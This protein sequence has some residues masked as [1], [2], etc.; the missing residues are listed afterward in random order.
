MIKYNFM[1]KLAQTSFLL[2]LL[3]TSG[4]LSAQDGWYFLS[5]LQLNGGNYAFDSYSRAIFIYGGLRYQSENF[6]ITASIPFVSTNSGRISQTNGMMFTAG[7]YNQTNTNSM[8]NKMNFGVGDLYVYMDHKIFSDY[9]S[10]ID[11]FINAQAKIPTAAIRMNIGTGKF[12]LGGSVTLRKSLNNFIGIADFGY[13]NIGDPDSIT[14][15][16]PFTY[17]IGVGKFFN[18]GEY[19]L[20]IYYT[21]YTKI[22]DGFDLPNLLSLGINYVA[23]EKVILSFISSKGF[24]NTSPDFTLSIGARIKI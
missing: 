7:N 20:L 9:E 21:G 17:G 4:K 3:L 1:R 18:Y 14:Y 11:L 23:A 16:N 10:G 24:G 5:N 12:D 15:K 19:S 13:L 6:G 8:Q 2:F 22:L